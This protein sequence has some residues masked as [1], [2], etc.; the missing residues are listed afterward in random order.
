MA[1]VF[2]STPSARR[3][4]AS[5]AL[6][7]FL[8]FIS[9]HALREEGDQ[10]SARRHHK[11]TDFYPRPPRGGR[12][13]AYLRSPLST[14]ISIH[15]LREEGDSLCRVA[16]LSLV[17]FLSTPSARR[18]TSFCSLS[19][20]SSLISIHA[21]REEGDRERHRQN[22]QHEH[23]YPR[24]P[25]GGRQDGH[26]GYFALDTISIHALRE[27]GDKY[28]IAGEYGDKTFLSTP[29][30]RRATTTMRKSNGFR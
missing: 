23:F 21:L 28:F 20:V 29:S 24:P 7:T 5:V 26:G 3:A 22:D 16:I 12:P 6:V 13:A 19:P 9:I 27:E 18:A 10:S 25:R 15:A 11:Q 30:A 17:R 1:W 14:T 4:T 8:A 2:L